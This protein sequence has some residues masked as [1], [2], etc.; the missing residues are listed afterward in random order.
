[1]KIVNFFA[2][3][4]LVSSVVLFS[5][6]GEDNDAD[7]VKP[8]SGGNNSSVPVNPVAGK[9]FRCKKTTGDPD[10][11]LI[12]TDFLISFSKDTF[13]WTLK[14]RVE[15]KNYGTGKWDVTYNLDKTFTGRYEYTETKI[16]LYCDNGDV[17][18]FT[19]VPEGWENLN[20]IYE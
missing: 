4:M 8:E 9:S 11:Q 12:Y 19:K 7:A 18:T 3:A 17:D 1:M 16:T 15:D 2:M 10:W 6:C 13:V 5:A 14:Q 20:Y